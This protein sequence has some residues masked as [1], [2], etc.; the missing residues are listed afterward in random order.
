MADFEARRRLR[1]ASSLSL[2]VRQLGCPPSVIGPSL[3]CPVL[4]TVCPNRPVSLTS[5][6]VTVFRGRLK[7]FVFRRSF[8]RL[9][10]QLLQCLQYPIYTVIIVIFGHLNRSFYVLSYIDLATHHIKFID[11]QR[12]RKIFTKVVILHHYLHHVYN[13]A[14]GATFGNLQIIGNMAYNSIR[15]V[16]RKFND[17]NNNNNDKPIH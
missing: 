1:S 5:A 16:I 14:N 13:N 7:A 15:T 8:P 12:S 4:G 2:N 9:S 6:P 10:I 3:S 17:N 11:T